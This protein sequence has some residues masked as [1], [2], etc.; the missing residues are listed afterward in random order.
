MALGGVACTGFGA[1]IA[2]ATSTFTADVYSISHSGVA[3]KPVDKT[4]M[5]SANSRMDFC[6]AKLVDSGTYE[7]ELAFN[8]NGA[9]VPIDGATEVITLSYP[10][11]TGPTTVAKD[12]FSGFITN[13]SEKVPLD[14]R[15]TMTV[16]LK[17]TGLIVRTAGVA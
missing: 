17:I 14:D 11:A 9:A 13:F 3:R 8:P 4:H 15:M 16:T 6:P 2:F 12:V 7:L 5:G 10:S 1:T